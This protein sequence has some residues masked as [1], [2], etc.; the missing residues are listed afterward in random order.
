MSKLKY[1][2]GSEGK[3]VNL[4]DNSWLTETN[5]VAEYRAWKINNV[6][7]VESAA[8]DMMENVTK[9]LMDVDDY[10]S[11][12]ISSMIYVKDSSFKI[13]DNTIFEK[14]KDGI[15]K[16][17]DNNMKIIDALVNNYNGIIDDIN[18]ALIRLYQNYNDVSEAL[19]NAARELEE[20]KPEEHNAILTNIGELQNKLKNNKK[21]IE[22]IFVSSSWVCS[23][24]PPAIFS[25]IHIQ[26]A[27]INKPSNINELKGDS[28]FIFDTNGYSETISF[29]DNAID[30]IKS[31]YGYYCE[32]YTRYLSYY[33]GPPHLDVLDDISVKSTM[34]ALSA[35]ENYLKKVKWICNNVKIIWERY[36]SESFE[37]NKDKYL[38]LL[39]TLP[40]V[41]IN[42]SEYATEFN[43]LVD[44]YINSDTDTDFS[45]FVFSYNG[46]LSRTVEVI[47]MKKYYDIIKENG[48]ISSED[49]VIS[50][51]AKEADQ[52]PELNPGGTPATEYVETKY[53][54]TS[55]DG[56]GSSSS[57][58]SSSSDSSSSS[59]SDSS[60]KA[61][62]DTIVVPPSNE[63][64]QETHNETKPENHGSEVYVDPQPEPA[65]PVV[66][67]TKV[68][69]K[70]ENS[71]HG[72]GGY[73][74]EGY[75]STTTSDSP[76]EEI[77]EDSPT[78]LED[79]IKDNGIYPEIA[80]KIPI[81]NHG[82]A[83]TASGSNVIPIVAGLTSVGAAGL[84]SKAYLDHK[85][86][87]SDND[88]YDEADEYDDY[89]ETPEKVEEVDADV[90]IN[91]NPDSDLNPLNNNESNE[92]VTF[93]D[94][95]YS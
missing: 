92:E 91:D 77:I 69:P 11:I 52:E 89:D 43:Q 84:G 18:A 37:G 82:T 67:P 32:S 19:Y 9:C 71:Y 24:S 64:K 90:I 28:D 1:Y 45:E 50:L 38:K 29:I 33:F 13:Y 81:E 60:K 42:S 20:K 4:I 40:L 85:R 25:E 63:K 7:V 14:A 22:E 54:S 5:Y 83:K 44:A 16:E 36:S 26:D 39:K 75:V 70:N 86:N 79:V 46:V 21:T 6:R 66:E 23:S 34:D 31:Y 47:D 12:Y 2:G 94:D 59:S 53:S 80:R 49:Y 57:S 3:P 17:H 87:N 55:S 78:S 72:G 51:L 58:S 61:K 10:I 48:F 27:S 73:S 76:V 8:Y 74:S 30:V 62:E 65:N 88:E 95:D 41:G 93:D 56:G 68:V 15:I 35:M